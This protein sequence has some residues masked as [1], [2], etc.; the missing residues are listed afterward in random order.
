MVKLEI[1]R[2]FLVKSDFAEYNL[3][4]L[5][6]FEKYTICQIYLNKPEGFKGSRRIRHAWQE[7]KTSQFY[8]TEKTP[9]KSLITK[10]EKE[11]EISKKEYQVLLKKADPQRDTILKHR[12]YFIWKNQKFELDFFLE[13]KRITSLVILEIELQDP[14]QK[15]TLPDFLPIMTEITNSPDLS[16]SNLSKRP[17]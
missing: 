4:K 3:P 8:F 17:T 15:V 16:N 5:L 10:I 2:R 13:P 14:K 9:T 1:E 6:K 7:N 11:R 12:L